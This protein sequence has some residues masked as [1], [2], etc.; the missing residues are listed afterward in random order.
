M[1]GNNTPVFSSGSAEVWDF[2]HTQKRD[3]ET[4]LEVSNDVVTSRDR[5]PG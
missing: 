2:I 5:A 4:I 1:T 3:P